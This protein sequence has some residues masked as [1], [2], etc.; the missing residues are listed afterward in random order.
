MEV[1]TDIN[2]GNIEN[3]VGQL[4]WL[5][6]FEKSIASGRLSLYATGRMPR[7]QKQ[8]QRTG[9]VA[10][11]YTVL[12]AMWTPVAAV[13]GIVAALLTIPNHKSQILQIIQILFAAIAI[14]AV[15]LA[16]IRQIQGFRAGRQFAR[17]QSD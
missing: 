13:S 7:W 14:V 2:S 17:S 15:A 10:M 8:V 1:D 11:G 6:P 9:V 3:V 12:A 5:T 4:N 16:L